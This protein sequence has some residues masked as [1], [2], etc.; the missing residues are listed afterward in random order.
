MKGAHHRRPLLFTTVE[1]P[2]AFSITWLWENA[3]VLDA[4]CLE[5]F[6]RITPNYKHKD[7]CLYACSWELFFQE[8]NEPFS[9]GIL[10]G[11]KLTFWRQNYFF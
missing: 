7:L 11:E 9:A 2:I 4:S 6:E 8:R 1:I 5:K 3:V 10:S